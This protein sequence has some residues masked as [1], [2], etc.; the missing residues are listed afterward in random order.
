MRSMLYIGTFLVVFGMMMTSICKQY[1][2]F[3]L[4]QGLVVGLGQTTLFLPSVAL[5]PAYF[6]RKR[7]AALGLAA[8]GSSIGAYL[9]SSI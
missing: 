6:E 5:I 4:A 7:G 9:F 2:Q 8:T 1:W 3:I